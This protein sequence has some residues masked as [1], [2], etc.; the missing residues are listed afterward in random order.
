M[1]ARSTALMCTNT[2]LLPSL[3]SMNP[4][5]FWVLKNFTVPVAIL[6]SLHC[7][8]CVYPITRASRGRSSNFG[9][10]GWAPQ[11]GSVARQTENWLRAAIYVTAAATSTQMP[12]LIWRRPLHWVIV[13]LVEVLNGIAI[14]GLPSR[15]LRP[16]A[17]WA[18]GCTS[19]PRPTPK[20]IADPA[21][22][23]AQQWRCFAEPVSL[24]A[25]RSF[26]SH[27]AELRLPRAQLCAA[28]PSPPFF[29]VFPRCVCVL[30][31]VARP[32]LDGNSA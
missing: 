26:A 24:K 28:Q 32:G 27:P 6:A 25:A 19:S 14:E 5:P 18:R 10:A 29:F 31:S 16:C 17:H 13:A 30:P 21:T 20:A 2:S 9:G 23:S 11:N 8:E 12:A 4:K 22:F 1:P 7:N 15:G 3:G